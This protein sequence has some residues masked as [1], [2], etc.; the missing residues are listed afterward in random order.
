MAATEGAEDNNNKRESNVAMVTAANNDSNID[1]GCG[2]NDDNAAVVRAV[3]GVQYKSSCHLFF[4]WQEP[5]SLKPLQIEIKTDRGATKREMIFDNAHQQI[6]CTC[7]LLHTNQS[8]NLITSMSIANNS[9]FGDRQGML[10]HFQ[11]ALT[12]AVCCFFCS[13][14]GFDKKPACTHNLRSGNQPVTQQLQ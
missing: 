13:R 4:S 11:H 2:G 12:I 10:N 7:Q 3:V 9:I 6:N 5:F 14:S 1:S 8:Y